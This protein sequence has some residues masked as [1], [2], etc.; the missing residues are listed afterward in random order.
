MSWFALREFQSHQKRWRYLVW[1]RFPM[2]LLLSIVIVVLTIHSWETILCGSL[3][4]PH[5]PPLFWLI[6]SK[7]I[8]SAQWLLPVIKYLGSLGS[9]FP[10]S[11]AAHCLCSYHLCVPL[12]A[13]NSENDCCS[14]AITV[15]N[16]VHYLPL[17]RSPVLSA[18][19]HERGAD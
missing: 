11:N 14:I 16:K 10:S 2:V 12:W 4:F 6:F 5:W 3:V 17:A 8:I 13:S 18:S 9:G 15:S 19:I 7:L 1:A